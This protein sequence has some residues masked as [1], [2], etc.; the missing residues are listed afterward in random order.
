MTSKLPIELQRRALEPGNIAFREELFHPDVQAK[1]ASNASVGVHKAASEG[2]KG[3]GTSLPHLDAIQASFGAH[4]VGGVHAH[5][6]AEASR[7]AESM[8]AEAYAM[9]DHVAFKESPD[10]H[11]AAHE[12]AHVVQQRGGV[13]LKDGVG[14]AGDSYEQHADAVADFVVQRRSAEELIGEKR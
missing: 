3:Q 1:A 7:S 10:L 6:D 4:D 13:Q 12:A 14:E 11:T 5:L 9:G 2:V 8:G